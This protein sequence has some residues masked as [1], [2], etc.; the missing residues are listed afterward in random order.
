MTGHVGW[1]ARDPRM[2]PSLP[3]AMATVAVAEQPRHRATIEV[4]SGRGADNV[5]RWSQAHHL[6]H[7]WPA[8]D[9]K[10]EVVS[11]A[12]WEVLGTCN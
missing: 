2:R 8:S 10:L 11:S 4:G 9:A 12:E 5:M 1:L 6:G 7:G 3:Q